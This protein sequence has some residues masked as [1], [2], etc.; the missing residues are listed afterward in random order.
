MCG[1]EEWIYRMSEMCSRQFCPKCLEEYDAAITL[2]SL[3]NPQSLAGESSKRYRV[4]T[5]Q[6]QEKK[7]T[8]IS[9]NH[10]NRQNYLVF[11]PE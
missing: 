5:Y 3:S 2:A 6:Y 7:P 10:K 4:T 9:N 8:I 1:N 11:I